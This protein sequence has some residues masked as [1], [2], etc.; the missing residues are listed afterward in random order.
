MVSKRPV[1]A[2]SNMCVL[3]GAMR[4]MQ[5]GVVNAGRYRHNVSGRQD[6]VKALQRVTEFR[7]E[8]AREN[9]TC[10]Q[11]TLGVPNML[12]LLFYFFLWYYMLRGSSGIGFAQLRFL[13]LA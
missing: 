10:G 8:F 9:L 5:N 3:D 7:R 2:Y 1:I 6:S 11:V 13:L 4:N 12:G